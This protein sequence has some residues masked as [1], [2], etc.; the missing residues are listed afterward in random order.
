MKNVLISGGA[1]F[2]GSRL[3]EKLF[4]KGYI[5]TIL[6]NL[7]PQIHGET[8]S[9]LFKK[10][11]DKCTF[12]KGDVR[13]KE[14]W[15]KAIKNQEIIIHL[16]AETGT[17]QSM[18]DISNYT[19]V[20]VMGTANMLEV[21]SENKGKVEKI[22]LASSRSVYGEGKYICSK[23]GDIFFPEQRDEKD[24]LNAYFEIKNNN[25]LLQPVATDEKSQVNPLSIYAINK[26]QQEQMTFF[27]G[28]SLGIQVVCL[29]YQNVYGPGQS[30]SNP[31]TGIL[32][33]FSTR[34]LNNND[35]D[36][37]EDGLQSRD[38]VYI[39]DVV[40]AT[41]LAVEKNINENEIINIGSG[42]SKTV[43]DV[44]LILKQYYESNINISISGNYRL[45]DIRH[46]FADI[47]KAKRILD[48]NP[49]F[50]FND[51]VLNFVQWVKKQK[52]MEDN[53][54]KSVIKLKEK[55]LLK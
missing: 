4:D 47:K 40:D 16:A 49:K 9:Y 32:S 6:D 42:S 10:V 20:N 51:G 55:G 50:S 19:E 26:L 15:K 14:D 23:K 7:S 22:I 53:Y 27:I 25:D 34:I 8:E 12:I 18:Y 29:R 5:I 44:A 43:K 31:Y 1:G 28:K 46:N 11:K 48:F 2:I 3:C 33:V 41:N 36:I 39:D 24:L 38:F 21:L 30:L 45:G 37:Y 17:G 35:I 13:N 52:I 54:E